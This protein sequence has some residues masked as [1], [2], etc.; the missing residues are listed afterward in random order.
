MDDDEEEMEAFGLRAPI[1][2]NLQSI[3]QDYP[4]GQLLAEALQNSEDARA[5]TFALILDHRQHARADPKSAAALG[6]DGTEG[7][8][9]SLAC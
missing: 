2:E 9:D 5:A 8:T 6:P 3:L 1:I 4:G 7:E